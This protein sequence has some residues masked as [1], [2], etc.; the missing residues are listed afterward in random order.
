[1]LAIDEFPGGIINRPKLYLMRFFRGNDCGVGNTAAR[2]TMD[3][4]IV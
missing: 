1:V 2:K 4:A 3:K